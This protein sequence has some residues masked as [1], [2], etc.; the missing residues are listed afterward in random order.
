MINGLVKTLLFSLC[1]STSF[2]CNCASYPDRIGQTDSSEY[3]YIFMT[4]QTPVS[5]FSVSNDHVDIISESN[6]IYRADSLADIEQFTSINN[7]SVIARDCPVELYDY[8][9]E[10]WYSECGINASFDLGITGKGVKVAVVDTGIFAEHDAFT[11]NEIADGA[12]ICAYLDKASTRYSDVSDPHGHG[13]A[14]TSV[15]S[16]I[17]TEATLVPLK[18]YDENSRYS[19]TA[20]SVLTAMQYAL[21]YDIDIINFSAG[22][23]NPS[24]ELLQIANKLTANLAENGTIMIAATGNRGDSDNRAEYPASCDKVI[25]VGAVQKSGGTYVRSSFSTANESI[26]VTA[27]GYGIW[28]ADISGNDMYVQKD[29]TSFSAQIVAAMAAGVKQIDPEIDTEKFKELLKKTATDIDEPGYDT[30][31][32][33]GLID[34]NAM[35]GAINPVCCIAAAYNSDGALLGTNINNEYKYGDSL[36]E[37]EKAPDCTVKYLFWDSLNGMRP[38]RV[39]NNGGVLQ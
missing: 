39:Y 38:S 26:L 35:F 12:N 6:N 15:I 7:I 10:D 37:F 9:D 2:A 11:D 27:P 19:L 34:F 32:G 28:C 5:L 22:F 23:S 17:A 13:T 18:I 33:Y 4:D 29:G 24:D 30:N 21:T 31:T 16:Q 1:A 3:G 20:S 25:G 14:V 8:Q 36:P